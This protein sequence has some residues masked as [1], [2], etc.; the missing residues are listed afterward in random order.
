MIG[1][2]HLN[3][4]NAI[5]VSE[6]IKLI[7]KASSGVLFSMP[8]NNGGGGDVKCLTGKRLEKNGKQVK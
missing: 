8:K 2:K 7:I 3:A 1:L 5:T 6:D 4:G